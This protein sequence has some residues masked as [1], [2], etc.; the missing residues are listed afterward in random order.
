MSQTESLTTIRERNKRKRLIGW[1]LLYFF[2][3]GG[4]LFAVYWQ[5]QRVNT[6]NF[7]NGELQLT[8]SKI[9][10]TAGDTVSYTLKN[11]L[12]VPITLI[13]RCPHTPVYVYTW[14][15]NSWMRIHDSA[16][17]KTCANQ[18]SEII[19]S[20]GKSY[21][22]SFANWPKLFNKPGIY[23]I[24]EL[25]TNYTA[26]PYA[27]FEV[28]AKPVAPVIQTRTQIVIQKVITPIYISAPT[29]GG[30]GGGGGGGDN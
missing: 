11:G 29:G 24:V 28:V 20:P 17:A 10:Y 4:I 7:A 13:N 25:A 15:N 5:A 16:S 6:L 21:N 19:I 30:D 8:T 23:R 18:P 14:T 26:L 3:I 1:S 27:D 9:K 2:L 12:Q 22:Q